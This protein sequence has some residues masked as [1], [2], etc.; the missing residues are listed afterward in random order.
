[1]L[2]VQNMWM[3]VKQTIPLLRSVFV[4]PSGQQTETIL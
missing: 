1:M 4:V 3:E 2:Y